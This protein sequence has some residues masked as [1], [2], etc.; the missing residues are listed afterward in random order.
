MADRGEGTLGAHHQKPVAA[1]RQ[2]EEIGGLLQ[3]VGALDIDEAIDIAA[4]EEA[5]HLVG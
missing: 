5:V 3:S 4:G 2:I 1:H